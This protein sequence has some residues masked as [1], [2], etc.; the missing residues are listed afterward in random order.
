MA[1]LVRVRNVGALPW[2]GPRAK[3]N[4]QEY[5]IP[6]GEEIICDGEIACTWLGYPAMRDDPN[7]A[8]FHRTEAFNRLR[9]TYGWSAGFDQEPDWEEMRPKLEVYTMK[10]ERIWMILDD[11]E[12]K[13]A[14]PQEDVVRPD[15]IEWLKA[16]VARQ[17]EELDALKAQ[18]AAR[19]QQGDV[20]SELPEDKPRRVPVGAARGKSQG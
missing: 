14:K 6:V 8:Q 17:E 11:P 12:G 4:N 10:G 9:Q 20:P 18:T 5:P 13:L 1:A 3:F 7:K 19:E 2:E 16:Q 15:D